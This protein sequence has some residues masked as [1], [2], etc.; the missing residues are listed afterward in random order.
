MIQK[1][2]DMGNKWLAASSR[3]RT[4]SCIMSH[5][6]ILVKPQITQVTQSPYSTGLAP[7]DFLHFPKTQITFDREEISDHQWDSGK[8][9]GAADGDC[10]ICVRSQGALFERAKAPLS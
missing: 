1:A 6:E 2:T 9:N 3:Q 10:K 5:A 8:Y 4:F 7:C